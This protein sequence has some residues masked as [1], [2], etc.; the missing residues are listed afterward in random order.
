[1]TSPS[2]VA[3]PRRGAPHTMV[4]GR[5]RHTWD[6]RNRGQT[7]AAAGRGCGSMHIDRVRL[8]QQG[9][10]RRGGASA[11]RAHRLSH[12]GLSSHCRRGQRAPKS[13]HGEG[14]E[15]MEQC[16][17]MHAPAGHV[18]SQC[19]RHRPPTGKGRT[20]A[21]FDCPR[22]ARPLLHRAG[23]WLGRG[24]RGRCGGCLRTR[25]CTTTHTA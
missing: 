25:S 9:R 19:R 1:M 4:D 23:A 3:H 7:R 5:T 6:W 11:C 24:G 21:A 20:T 2:W 17:W 16:P 10:V 8:P 14:N 12:V 18:P 13:D 22:R 15:R